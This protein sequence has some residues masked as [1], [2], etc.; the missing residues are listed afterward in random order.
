MVGI[1]AEYYKE[2]NMADNQ[3]DKTI[4]WDQSHRFCKVF[5]YTDKKN[6]WYLMGQLGN[7]CML[8][9]RKNT[10]QYAKHN[11]WDVQIIPIKYSKKQ[12]GPQSGPPQGRPQSGPPQNGPAVQFEDNVDFESDSFRG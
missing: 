6:N 4:L 11:E 8:S 9:I 7:N 12:D 10:G 2:Q 1:M 5:E 3:Y